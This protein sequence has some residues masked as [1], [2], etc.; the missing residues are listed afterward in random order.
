MPFPRCRS[1]NFFIPSQQLTGK[2]VTQSW[3]LEGFRYCTFVLCC[4]LG[5]KLCPNILGFEKDLKKKK[6]VITIK[7][8]TILWKRT[9]NTD[10]W[11]MVTAL[12]NH[13]CSLQKWNQGECMGLPETI[14]GVLLFVYAA[15]N[16]YYRRCWGLWDIKKW[17]T[18][19]CHSR[20]G[21]SDNW[22]SQQPLSGWLKTFCLVEYSCYLTL[23]RQALVTPY[24]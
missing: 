24:W 11:L 23:D 13:P 3:S 20:N 4:L 12:H 8:S 10:L 1:G 2:T 7:N 6:A 18:Q 17:H 16:N 22:I 9:E 15:G 19:R 5:G 14:S 21:L